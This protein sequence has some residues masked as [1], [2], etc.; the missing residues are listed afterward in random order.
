MRM[1]LPS[2]LHSNQDTLSFESKS[3]SLE[4]PNHPAKERPGARCSDEQIGLRMRE[5][6]VE[7]FSTWGW[8]RSRSWARP[9]GRKT[10]RNRV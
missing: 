2:A 10:A 9:K 8:V 5:M 6:S 1:E 3:A 7:G 4:T